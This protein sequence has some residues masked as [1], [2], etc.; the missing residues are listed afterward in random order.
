MKEEIIYKENIMKKIIQFRLS[1]G[2]ILDLFGI[3]KEMIGS[4]V[5]VVIPKK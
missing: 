1:R 2:S 5:K 4:V 3:F